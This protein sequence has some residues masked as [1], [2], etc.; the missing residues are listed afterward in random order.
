MKADK[1]RINYKSNR[2]QKR[3]RTRRRNRERD[4]AV[5]CRDGVGTSE[6]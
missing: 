5:G 2:F 3:T 1:M 6:Q 4:E